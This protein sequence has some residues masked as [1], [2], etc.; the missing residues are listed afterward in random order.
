[1]PSVLIVDDEAD[2]QLICRMN[3]KRLHYQG[4]TIQLAT[5]SS[6]AEAIA[7]MQTH[8]E[9]WVIL[10][11]IVMESNHAGLDAI[12]VIRQYNST[13]QIVVHTGQAG[14]LSESEVIQRYAIEGYLNKGSENL[15]TM[16]SAVALALKAYAHRIQLDREK[17]AWEQ[18]SKWLRRLL[19]TNNTTDLRQYLLEAVLAITGS[20]TAL[21]YHQEAQEHL[22]TVA[23]ESWVKDHF[24]SNQNPQENLDT[25]CLADIGQIYF[26]RQTNQ[27]ASSALNYCLEQLNSIAQRISI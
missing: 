25:V 16:H 2:I 18:A 9:T 11:D 19:G 22:M 6:A 7:Y 10:M 15:R 27:P 26:E 14:L 1:M 8:P 21:R 17:N 24:Q 12:E 23:S 5:A 3:L 4:Q 13:T 20:P